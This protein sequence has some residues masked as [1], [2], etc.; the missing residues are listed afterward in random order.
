MR[1]RSDSTHDDFLRWERESTDYS[2]NTFSLESLPSES[3]GGTHH[4]VLAISG[5]LDLAAAPR[6][7]EA[8]RFASGTVSIDCQSLSFIDASGIRVLEEAL[9][10][11]DHIRLINV[12]PRVRKVLT[13]VGL[14]GTFL[15]GDD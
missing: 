9:G 4:Q 10:H 5:E 11:L 15:C 2:G 7:T 1:E 6:L 14:V 13:I 8:L 12:G 3:L